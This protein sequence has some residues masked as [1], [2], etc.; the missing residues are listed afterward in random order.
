MVVIA[1]PSVA[2]VQPDRNRE[3]MD[4][5]IARKF[6]RPFHRIGKSILRF[7][8]GPFELPLARRARLTQAQQSFASGILAREL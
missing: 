5:T 8:S 4:R 2:E 6:I 7:W 3:E 1:L